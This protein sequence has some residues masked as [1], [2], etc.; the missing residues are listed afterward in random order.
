MRSFVV[1]LALATAPT[2][3]GAEAA[4]PPRD[5]AIALAEE[6]GAAAEAP[7]NAALIGFLA[8]HPDGPKAERARLLLRARPAAGRTAAPG[9][10]GDIWLAFDAARALGTPTA[11][12]AFAARYPTHP[13]AI[14]AA[15]PFWTARR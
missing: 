11:M 9:P 2:A 15:L 10:D 3:V 5:P 4:A 1:L 7:G 6:F 8:R 12:A 14:E 13:L